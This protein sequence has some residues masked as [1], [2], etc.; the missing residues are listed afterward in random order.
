MSSSVALVEYLRGRSGQYFADLEGVRARV[1][2]RRVRRRA[3]STLQEFVLGNASSQHVILVKMPSNDLGSTPPPACKNRPRMFPETSAEFKGRFEYQAMSAIERF[4]ER[5]GDPRFG[6][7]RVLDL[8]AEQQAVVMEKVSERTLNSYIFKDA[9][10]FPN[11]RTPLQLGR[12][13]RNTGS[14]LRHYHSLPGL[15]HTTVRGTDRAAFIDSVQRLAEYLSD[16]YRCPSYEGLGRELSGLAD[17]L[18]PAELPL[19]LGHGD[20]APRN[21]LVGPDGKIRVIDT[22]SRWVAPIFEDLACFLISLKTSTPQVWSWGLAYRRSSTAYLE[23]QF[24]SGYFGTDRPP[25]SQ[26]QLF[27]CQ[28]L[29]ERWA[30]AADRFQRMQSWKRSVGALS[31][32]WRNAYMRREWAYLLNELRS[33]DSNGQQE[34]R[35]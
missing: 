18:L 24:L 31:S 32:R 30:A 3:K 11:R 27:E 33:G 4:V 22:I 23:Q 9:M 17:E 1:L 35:Y 14:W 7:V 25:R 19:G 2:L 8:L 20:F 28:G 5:L 15:E 29:L 21:V 6:A 16:F 34:N 13:V 12:A 10:A 26:I